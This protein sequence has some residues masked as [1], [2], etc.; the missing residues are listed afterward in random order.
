MAA[1]LPTGGVGAIPA[2]ATGV[3]VGAGM[4]ALFGNAMTDFY[5]KTPIA[6]G[7]ANASRW[8]GDFFGGSG[9]PA[10]AGA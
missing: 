3:V 10:L 7:L 4:D 5:T 9:Q 1:G 8:I 6:Q 2:L